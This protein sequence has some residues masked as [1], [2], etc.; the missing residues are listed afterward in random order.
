MPLFFICPMKPLYFT[1]G[2]R[3][4][5]ALV[6]S[7]SPEFFNLNS[8]VGYVM[9]IKKVIISGLVAGLAILMILIVGM[10][11]GIISSPNY[12]S[13]PTLWKEM[14]GNWWYQITAWDF[15]EGILY[16]AVFSI[17]FNGIPGSGW[18]KGLNY[19]IILWL[20]ATVPA[21]ALI[22]LTMTVPDTIVVSWLISGLVSLAIA[23]ITISIVYEKIK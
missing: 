22:Y 9:D 1:Y 20:V 18:R 3:S 4:V 13:T 6:S 14:T 16:A 19:G 11:S 5:L 23:G 21:M 7:I 17:L 12:T 2:S 8:K 15:I 10:V